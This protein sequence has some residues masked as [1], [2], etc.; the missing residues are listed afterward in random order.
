MTIRCCI[1]LA[2]FVAAISALSYC[3]AG[4]ESAEGSLLGRAYLQLLTR[5]PADRPGY[6]LDGYQSATDDQPMTCGY[7]LSAESLRARHEKAQGSAAAYEDAK[8]HVRTAAGW[9][10]ENRD[11]DQDGKS[12]WGLPQ[13]W[14][15]WADGT[16]NPPH[17]PYTITTAIV[18]TGLLDALQV[19]EAFD[20]R[21][22]KEIVT[23]IRDVVLRWCNEV[24][25][26]G[27]GGGYFWYSPSQADEIFGVNA[28]AMFLTPLVRLLAEHPEALSAEEGRLVQGRADALAAAIVHTVALRDGEP[29]WKY[30]PVPNRLDHDKPNDL[31]HHVYTLFGIERY[32]DWEGGR[33]EI[34]WPR[35]AAVQSVDRFL[36]WSAGKTPEPRRILELPEFDAPKGGGARLW[37]AGTMLGFYG[38]AG[39][40]AKAGQVFG[41]IA[42]DYGPFPDL[43]WVPAAPGSNT[44][45]YLR[46]D[47]H[48][49]YGLA[50]V[51]FR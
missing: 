34:P 6:G 1:Y 44:P 47:A 50:L 20:E 32:R 22:R 11:L 33:V 49:L 4:E 39:A 46:H 41:L 21:E 2:T 8:T 15:A 3:E 29:F 40:N 7:Y 37:G 17:Q 23:L 43:R 9:L 45:S 26:E 16:V 42:K 28:P 5:F 25:S 27:Y 36:Q 24:W 12:G 14:D 13:D 38:Y 35:D 10:V 31:V 19:P 51:L 48:I 30:A 18:L